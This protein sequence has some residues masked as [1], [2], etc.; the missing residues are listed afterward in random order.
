M[1]EHFRVFPLSNWTE[2]DIWQYI[3]QEK[4]AIP[5]LY[6]AHKRNMVD[7][8]G[9]LLYK[10]EFLP[11]KK[12]EVAKEM[13]IRFRTIGDMTCTGAEESDADTLEKIIE[14]VASAR[15]TERGGRA[16]DKRSETSMEDRKKQ[17][18]F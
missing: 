18:Y 10:S 9:V 12:G 7:R 1:G 5:N 11:D 16:D 15:K 17:G 8:N 6:F 2:M 13:L 4:I 3:L 14:E